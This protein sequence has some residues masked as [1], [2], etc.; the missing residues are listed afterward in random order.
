M[1]QVFHNPSC[2]KSR[3]AID[4]LEIK[5]T[6]Y[7]IIDYLNTHLSAQLLHD[8]LGKL[9]MKPIE[10]LRTGEQ[11]FKELGLSIDDGRSDTEWIQIMIE[12]P[13]LIERP[14]IIKDDKAVIGRPP[15]NIETL[16]K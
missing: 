9:G 14:I 1:I 3:C 4:N 13:I 16:F 7:E 12:N 2:S 6:E 10:I 8:V 15:E 5:N 11:K